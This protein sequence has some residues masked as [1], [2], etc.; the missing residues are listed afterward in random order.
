MG[1]A[2]ISLAPMID[3]LQV[4]VGGKQR[5][6]QHRLKTSQ[7]ITVFGTATHTIDLSS[8]GAGVILDEPREVGASTP[9]ALVLPARDGVPT[10]VSGEAEVRAST[11]LPEGRHRI[12]LEFVK[13]DDEARLVIMAFCVLGLASD[14]DAADV[15]SVAPHELTVDR[16][17]GRRRGLQA[18]TVLAVLAGTGMALQAPASAAGVIDETPNGPQPSVTVV[19]PD[20]QPAE[21]A[22]RVFGAPGTTGRWA[23]VAERDAEGGWLVPVDAGATD[24]SVQGPTHVEV[25]FDGARWVG[26]YAGAD[27]T[28][29]L[30]LV[31]ADEGRAVAALNRGDDWVPF[32]GGTVLPGR[33]AVQLDDGTVVKL[34]VAPGVQVRVPSGQVESL[35]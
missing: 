20:G 3:V 1:A 24:G 30:S 21:V 35:P 10:V 9:F 15:A 6:A 27:M 4:V 11:A 25:A 2:L 8:S 23:E 33:I 22:V 16:S 19:G 28:L 14:L 34:D 17:A 26:D 5:R 29:R 31:V 18:A 12:G 7:A 32:A 13:V